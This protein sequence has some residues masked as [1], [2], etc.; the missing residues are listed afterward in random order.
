M[1]IDNCIIGLYVRVDEF[2]GDAPKH[3][4]ASL[5]PS[6]LVALGLLFAL[7]GIGQRPFYRWLRDNYGTRFPGLPERTRLF[8][9]FATHRAWADCFLANPTILGVADTYGIELIHPWREGRSERQS[10][11]KGVS[12][13]RWIVDVKLAT[14]WIIWAW[15]LRGTV[16]ARM[17]MT[18]PSNH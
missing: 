7:K 9:L 15:L 14:S 16:Q 3:P 5:H 8:R 17:P 10:G 18:Q 1:S 4:Q 12:N 13:H 2:M 11:R 6:E